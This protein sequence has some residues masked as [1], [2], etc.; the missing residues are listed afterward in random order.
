MPMDEKDLKKLI[1]EVKAVGD[2]GGDM[3]TSKELRNLEDA[4]KA[5]TDE[6]KAESAYNRKQNDKNE[7]LNLFQIAIEE[8]KR[9]AGD[10]KREKEF[11][12]N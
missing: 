10:Q 6:L 9:R 11:Y 1:D 12:L 7:K 3:A 5:E 2:S 8:F 4:I